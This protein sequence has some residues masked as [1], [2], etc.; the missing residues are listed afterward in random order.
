[1]LLSNLGNRQ[2][3]PKPVCACYSGAFGYCGPG[4]VI[5]G[6]WLALLHTGSTTSPSLLRW[7]CVKCPVVLVNSTSPALLRWMCLVRPVPLS[8]ANSIQHSKIT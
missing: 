7:M 3:G 8:L 6:G 2:P 5:V 1:M 4:F